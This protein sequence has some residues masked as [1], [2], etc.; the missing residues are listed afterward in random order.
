LGVN[1]VPTDR[2]RKQILIADLD[3]T[4]ITNKSPDD[5]AALAV[6]ANAVS[7]TTKRAMAGEIDFER[8]SMLASKSYRLFD[9]LITTATPTSGAIELVNTMRS[10]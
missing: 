10:N 5:L 6:L 8:V 3:N 7:A 9:Q 4:T 1:I 2:R